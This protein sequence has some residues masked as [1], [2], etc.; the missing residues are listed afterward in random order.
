MEDTKTNPIYDYP[1]WISLLAPSALLVILI[2]FG[3]LIF[4]V[5]VKP[6]TTSQLPSKVLISQYALEEQC[7]IR[8]TLIAVTAAGGIV[9]F[10]F[11]VLDV[12]KAHKTLQGDKD[13]PYLVIPGSN[14]SLTPAPETLQDVKLENGLVYYILY[15]NTRNLVKPGTPVSVVIGDW[16]LEPIFAK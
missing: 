16:I 13:L 11:K 7:G 3:F 1:R 8:I 5:Y 14:V 2:L 4:H 9:D 10:R 15:S 6:K 12:G